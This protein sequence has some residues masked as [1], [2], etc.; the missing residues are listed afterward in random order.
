MGFKK[1]LLNDSLVLHVGVVPDISI[2]GYS[3]TGN[4]IWVLTRQLHVKFIT[5][6][7]MS[8]SFLKLI[9][10][11]TTELTIAENTVLALHFN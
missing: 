10:V 1:C 3:D 11:N 7:Q 5:I 6:N 4:V 9:F 8:L 2:T